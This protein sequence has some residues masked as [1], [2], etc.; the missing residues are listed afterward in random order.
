MSV[1]NIILAST[2]VIGAALSNGTANASLAT[3]LNI[4]M[5]TTTEASVE[6]AYYPGGYPSYGNRRLC[7]LPFF[8]LVRYVGFWRAKMIKRN[9]YR[10]YYGY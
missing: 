5:P 6:Q 9:C 3:D 10:P 8:V 2:L 7:R 4:G 1:R